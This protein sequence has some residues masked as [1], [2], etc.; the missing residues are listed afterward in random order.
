M[1]MM[2]VN[3]ISFTY[4]Q[5]SRVE[6]ESFIQNTHPELMS[7]LSTTFYHFTDLMSYTVCET[8]K[9]KERSKFIKNGSFNKPDILK[10]DTLLYKQFAR[11]VSEI[12]IPRA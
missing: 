11:K 10:C 4:V 6:S 2:L 3:T 5:S 9:V 7:L 1:D 8:G 12:D